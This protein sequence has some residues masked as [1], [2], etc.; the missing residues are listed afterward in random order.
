[1]ASLYVYIIVLP[2]CDRSEVGLSTAYPKTDYRTGDGLT[3]YCRFY[4]LLSPPRQYPPRRGV[5]GEGNPMTPGQT[6]RHAEAAERVERSR[7]R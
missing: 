2:T 5:H 7:L 3:R 6:E 4:R 1:M